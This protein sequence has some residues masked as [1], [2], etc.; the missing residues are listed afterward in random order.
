MARRKKQGTIPGT[1]RTVHADITAAAEAYV[2][3]RDE[4]M[5][6][7]ENEV[8][9]NAKLVAA[10]K[11]HDL[12]EYIDEDAELKVTLPEKQVKAKV[13]KIKP[14]GGDDGE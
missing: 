14:K 5:E 3:V 2:E 8:E 6:M 1:E 11:K 7:T 13:S 12:T 10:M 9:A 4:R